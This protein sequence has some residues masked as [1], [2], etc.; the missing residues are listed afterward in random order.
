MFNNDFCIKYKQEFKKKSSS[1]IGRLVHK[2]FTDGQFKGSG[3]GV[4]FANQQF[5]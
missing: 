4:A 2:Y 5:Y 1:E 3:I